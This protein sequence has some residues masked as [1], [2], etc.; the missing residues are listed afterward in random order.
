MLTRTCSEYS[1]TSS[2]GWT[3][4]SNSSIGQRQRPGR[5]GRPRAVLVR[6]RHRTQAEM[7][8]REEPPLAYGERMVVEAAQNILTVDV[9]TRNGFPDK[10]EKKTLIRETYSQAY[11]LS[12][13]HMI[14]FYFYV[15]L[16]DLS[17]QSVRT[18]T[19]LPQKM[20]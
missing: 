5:D 17:I 2:A 11:S 12:G 7:P 3:I 4:A 13:L 1:D 15:R 18:R 8:N 16:S 10:H 6:R 14:Y 9:L 20:H 19:L